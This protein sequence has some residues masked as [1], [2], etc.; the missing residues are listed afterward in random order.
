MTEGER[1]RR[2]QSHPSNTTFVRQQILDINAN[3]YMNFPDF[4][5]YGPW[6]NVQNPLSHNLL[7]WPKLQMLDWVMPVS[8]ADRLVN[9]KLASSELKG[10]FFKST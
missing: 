7:Q 5:Y 4:C 8:M 6:P 10:C 3:M 9:G 1:H 2:L